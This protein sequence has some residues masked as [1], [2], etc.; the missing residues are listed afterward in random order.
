[1]NYLYL[2]AA[3]LIVILFFYVRRSRRLH[4]TAS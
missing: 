2:Y 4:Q 3:A 1:M